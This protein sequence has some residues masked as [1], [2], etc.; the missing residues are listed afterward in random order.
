HIGTMIGTTAM[1]G[2]T[3]TTL[4]IKNPARINQDFSLRF[5]L[6]AT[7]GDLQKLLSKIYDGEP[8]PA[9]QTLI[10]AGKVLKDSSLRLRDIIIQTDWPAG[11]HSFHLVIKNKQSTGLSAQTRSV[12]SSA[13]A[14]ATTATAA[15]SGAARPTPPSTRTA[16]TPDPSSASGSVASLNGTEKPSSSRPGA[17]PTPTAGQAELDGLMA[18]ASLLNSWIAYS[19]ASGGIYGAAFSNYPF[20]QS[21][22]PGTAPADGNHTGHEGSAAAPVAAAMSG[23][24]SA[25][26]IPYT[27][28]N[29]VVGNAY[30]AAYSAALAALSVGPQPPLLKQRQ[31]RPVNQAKETVSDEACKDQCGAA[32]G[33]GGEAIVEPNASAGTSS[34]SAAS[35]TEP[36]A[37]QYAYVPMFVP[38]YGQ[39]GYM[40]GMPGPYPILQ[41]SGP[42]PLGNLQ[43]PGAWAWSPSPF[44]QPWQQPI[45]AVGRA[46]A[47][48]SIDSIM[49]LNA[50]L[51]ALT[52]GAAGGRREGGRGEDGGAGLA[53]RGA[54]AG[55]AGEGQPGLRLRRARIAIPVAMVPG[56]EQ[57]AV[58]AVN[59][60]RQGPARWPPRVLRIRVSLRMLLQALV[61]VFML[62]QNLTW[63]RLM[64]LIIIGAVMYIASLW[65]PFLVRRDN[66]ARP[67]APQDRGEGAAGRAAGAAEEGAAGAALQPAPQLRQQLRRRGFLSEVLVFVVGFVTSLLPAWNFFAED[68]AAFVVGQQ[69]PAEED[70]AR[71]QQEAVGENDAAPAEGAGAV[72]PQGI[73]E[74]EGAILA[75]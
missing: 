68:A 60:N 62:S 17:D 38:A 66:Q 72:P 28:Y 30:Q 23:A 14:S 9:D 32:S 67:E 57:L 1:R 45:P 74:A 47:T 3:D 15:A 42:I 16:S 55:A 34:A 39:A 64:A 46:G 75:Q 41:Q 70:G 2:D 73:D 40:F 49:D 50:L 35:T 43:T 29:P 26:D 5:W 69:M 48:E 61:V 37:Q 11:P 58:A 18:A 24:G 51:D 59:R 65:A 4:V 12:G 71:Q 21:P 36:V 63:K 31:D 44:G 33:T 7:V 22:M 13:S 56:N 54:R 25:A 6:D 52:E 53:N 10:Y 19:G 20:A 27:Y 8:A